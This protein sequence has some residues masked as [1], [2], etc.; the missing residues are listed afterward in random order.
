LNLQKL[1]LKKNHSYQSSYGN[2][3]KSNVDN[4]LSNTFTP[5]NL[6]TTTKIYKL[7]KDIAKPNI[8]YS[9]KEMEKSKNRMHMQYLLSLK[10]SLRDTRIKSQIYKITK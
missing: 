10:N 9:M 3:K 7:T 8:D 1:E 4:V 6:P 2:L 5:N